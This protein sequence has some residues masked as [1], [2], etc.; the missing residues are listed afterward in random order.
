MKA[1]EQHFPVVLLTK[2]HKAVP[3]SKSVHEILLFDHLNE[4]QYA[5]LSCGTVYLVSSSVFLVCRPNPMM[6]P[7]K[8]T[9]STSPFT[10]YGLF[11]STEKKIDFFSSILTRYLLAVKERRKVVVCQQFLFSQLNTKLVHQRQIQRQWRWNSCN[12]F[13]F[14][15]TLYSFLNMQQS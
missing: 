10:W 9:L 4:S 15:P 3:T 1:T 8:S 5:V 6:L 13:I 11:V 12:S 2:L 14:L 7:F